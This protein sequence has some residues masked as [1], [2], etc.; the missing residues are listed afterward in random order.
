[1]TPTISII[2]P[3]YNAEKWLPRCF[4]SILAQDIKDFE[5][6]AVNDCSTDNSLN[7]IEKYCDKDKRFVCINKHQNEGADK[8]REDGLLRANGDFILFMDSDDTYEPLLFSKLIQIFS[9]FP[10]LNIIEFKFNQIVDGIKYPA[11]YLVRKNLNS[12]YHVNNE[13]ILL[14]TALW[15]KCYRTDFIKKHQLS[16][17]PTRCHA[18]GEIPFH[19]CSMLLA[20]EVYFLDFYG[21]NWHINAT[22]LSH[23]K[24][25]DKLFL[26]DTWN[27]LDFLKA[28]LLRLNLYNEKEY[29]QYCTTI[30]SWYL[31]EKFSLHY[32]F[33]KYY[34]T[35]KKMFTKWGTKKLPPYGLFI[36][37]KLRRK[38]KKAIL[39]KTK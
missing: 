4:D 8:A 24:A 1:M 12:V 23:N 3:V 6:I 37:K 5:V 13:N 36:W 33:Y 19:I 11:N 32:F 35:C 29:H 31:D 2:M 20:Q 22:S 14:A 26:S 30:L 9:N 25:K 7:I 28:E 21:Y 39:N 15:N 38:I 16:G 18:G 17:M 34:T 10:H 27:V